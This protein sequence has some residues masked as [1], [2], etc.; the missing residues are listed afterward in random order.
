MK[1]IGR[2]ILNG[3][4]VLS[5]VLCI[6]AAGLW[7]RSRRH[8]DVLGYEGSEARDF[9]QRGGYLSSGSGVVGCEWW[10]RQN[11]PHGS[12]LFSGWQRTTWPIAPAASAGQQD[13]WQGFQYHAETH[14]NS[15][16]SSDGRPTPQLM[17]YSHQLSAPHWFI[18][19]VFVFPVAL[20][21]RSELLRR[22]LRRR[23]RQMRCPTCGYDLRATPDRCP[24]CG[25]IPTEARRMR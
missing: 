13:G 8:M 20:W 2:H 5:L 22:R 21:L 12:K 9:W 11:S 16:P 23:Y 4:T 17:T 1:R 19:V 7:A 14:D 10:L 15:R 3:L 25:A 18:L 24:E 6:A